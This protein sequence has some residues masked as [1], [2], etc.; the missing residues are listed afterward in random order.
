[1]NNFSGNWDDRTINSRISHLL[2]CQIRRNSLQ[3]IWP[4]FLLFYIFTEFFC[5]GIYTWTNRTYCIHV[6]YTNS[7]IP[8]YT[9]R[10]IVSKTVKIENRYWSKS[11]N[12]SIEIRN[13]LIEIS[14]YGILFWFATSPTWI[15]H[16]KLYD[17]HPPGHSDTSYLWSQYQIFDRLRFAR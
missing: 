10:I 16:N 17:L 7:V 2:A 13:K 14:W 8:T 1:M 9:P 4:N 5:V 12:K 3:M 6:L 11:V 15:S